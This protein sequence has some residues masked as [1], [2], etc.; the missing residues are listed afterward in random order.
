MTKISFSVMIQKMSV[1]LIHPSVMI[2]MIHSSLINFVC[3]ISMFNSTRQILKLCHAG[4]M[5]AECD[6]SKGN[7]IFLH[8]ESQHS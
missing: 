1:V 4:E 7:P 2:D 6:I 8:K 3:E 5:N